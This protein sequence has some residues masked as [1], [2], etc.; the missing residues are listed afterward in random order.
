MKNRSRLGFT[1]VELL[2]V[3]AIIG[4][5]VGLLVPA[6]QAAREAAR[7]AQCATQ[8][9]NLSM[10]TIT[11]ETSKRQFPG[12]VNYF[13]GFRGGVDPADPL[14]SPPAHYKIGTVHV[15]LMPYLDQNPTYERWNEDKYPLLSTNPAKTLPASG[16]H[17]NSVPNMPLFQCPSAVTKYREGT[18]NYVA[19]NGLAWDPSIHASAPF[20]VANF[21]QACKKANGPFNAKLKIPGKINIEGLPVRT[22]DFA[23]GST[24][25]I[26]FSESMQAQPYHWLAMEDAASGTTA[27]ALQDPAVLNNATVMQLLKAF[28]GILFHPQFDPEPQIY[29]GALPPDVVKINGDKV[30]AIMS[31]GQYLPSFLARPSAMHPS[32]VN[33]TFADGQ[34]RFLTEDTDYAVYTALLTLRNKS[35]D[36]LPLRKEFI[37]ES[38]F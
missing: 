29:G 2:V 22:E 13:G 35:S 18:N 23:D 6:V 34:V 11:Y 38:P 25:T 30:D 24:N 36:V 27:S 3:I 21:E 10:A 16:F 1:L 14:S 12:Y 31:S 7:R 26:L 5:L 20:N 28:Q 17:P 37:P 15:A 9:K 33:A 19:N 4:I 32:G 8:M